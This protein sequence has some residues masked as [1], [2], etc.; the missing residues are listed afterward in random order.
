MAVQAYQRFHGSNVEDD[1]KEWL[2]WV[3]R[4]VYSNESRLYD[5]ANGLRLYIIE[6]ADLECHGCELAVEGILSRPYCWRIPTEAIFNSTEGCR[7]SRETRIC[8]RDLLEP[9]QGAI[10]R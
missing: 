7:W 2:P 9:W 10:L 1:D 3:F 6:K 5:L 4:D 8:E